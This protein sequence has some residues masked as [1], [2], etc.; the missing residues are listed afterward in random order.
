MGWRKE[1]AG[2]ALAALADGQLAVAPSP[3]PPYLVEIERPT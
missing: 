2:D 1:L 3:D